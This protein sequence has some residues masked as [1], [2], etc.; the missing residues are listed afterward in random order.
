MML[1]TNP[2][3]SSLLESIAVDLDITDDLHEEAVLKYEDVGDWLGVAGSPLAEYTPE[4]YP[5]GSFRLGTV[6]RPV[7]HQDQFDIDLVCRIAMDKERTTQ[8]D[9]KK[10]VGDRLKARE[11]LKKV[12][13]ESRRCWNLTFEAYFHMDVLPC[14]PNPPRLPNGLLLTDCDLIRWQKSNPIDYASW[15]Y[16]RMEVALKLKQ[17]QLAESRAASV[18]EVPIWQVRTPLQRVVQ[19]LKRHRDLYFG[20]ERENRP[21]S[22]IITTL[23]ARAYANQLDLQESLESI[24]AGMRGHIIYN[25]GRYWIPNPVEPDEN[26]ADKWNEKPARRLA[27]LQWLEQAQAD[28]TAAIERKSLSESVAVLNRSLGLSALARTSQRVGLG[29]SSGSAVVPAPAIF[30]APVLASSNHAQPS[31]WAEVITHRAKLRGDLYTNSRKKK[32]GDLGDRAF[33]KNLQIKFRV[34]T[35]A[36]PPYD[37]HWQVVNTGAEAS[38]VG[39]LRGDFYPSDGSNYRWERTGYAG[40]HWV[41]AFVVKDGYCI[42]R[43]GRKY[44]KVRG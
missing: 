37:V 9:L 2:M 15:F 26:F 31:R 8:A 34:E 23:A 3:I 39:Q 1:Y 6:V 7:A 20:D 22:I 41:E 33:P 17:I 16:A 10:L 43:S 35:N 11:D 32:I 42:A 29:E 25:N 36:R 4:I 12:L 18:E 38:A 28:F 5:Q 44:V 27:F 30:K 14:L 40:T 24:L 19:L 13:G 21:T